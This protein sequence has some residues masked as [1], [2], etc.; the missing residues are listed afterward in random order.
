V[1]PCRRA[2]ILNS[3]K[4]EEEQSNKS[5]YLLKLM[6]NAIYIGMRSFV[7]PQLIRNNCPA[8]QILLRHS[9]IRFLLGLLAGTIILVSYFL[10]GAFE[11]RCEVAVCSDIQGDP[12]GAYDSKRGTRNARLQPTNPPPIN[13]MQNRLDL[14]SLVS[15]RLVQGIFN[16]PAAWVLVRAQ[17]DILRAGCRVSQSSLFHL[18][19]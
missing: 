13:T 2:D 7:S 6:F 17:V 15:Q 3:E 16:R 9:A 12:V 1:I 4:N 14:C 18:L 11:A 5:T 19:L 10:E 8:I